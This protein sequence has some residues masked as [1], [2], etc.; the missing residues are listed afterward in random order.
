MAEYLPN[1]NKALSL[2]WRQKDQTFKRLTDRHTHTCTHA[3]THA[4]RER[5]AD[6][7]IDRH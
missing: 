6:T 5:E 7:E 1:M 3:C 4:Q 2:N